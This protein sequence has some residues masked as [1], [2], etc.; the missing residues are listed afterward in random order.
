MIDIATPH[1]IYCYIGM[2]VINLL[3]NFVFFI[4]SYFENF[5]NRE[6]K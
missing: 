6:K 3:S 2:F 4:E 1:S 5:Y